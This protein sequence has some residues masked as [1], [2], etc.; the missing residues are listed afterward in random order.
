M[1]APIRLID[2]VLITIIVFLVLIIV[3]TTVWVQGFRK[4]ASQAETV[5]GAEAVEQSFSGIGRL[6]V[7]P[8]GDR[9]KDGPTV[10]IRVVFPYNAADPIFT[11]ELVKNT[12]NFRKIID[13]YFTD[14]AAGD[15]RLHDETTIKSELLDDFN[16]ILR[17][18]KIDR[19]FFSEFLIID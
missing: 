7:V 9:G 4:H 5:A 6:R 12:G 10:I 15:P 3:L 18:G 1:P 2:K 11:E 19:L 13:T 17:L 16:Q 8:G 14:M